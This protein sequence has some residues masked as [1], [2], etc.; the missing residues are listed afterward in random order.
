MYLDLRELDLESWKGTGFVLVGGGL[1]FRIADFK[2]ID[3][4]FTLLL[5]IELQ[6]VFGVSFSRPYVLN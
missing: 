6:V 2:E 3:G 5:I 4:V 1:S